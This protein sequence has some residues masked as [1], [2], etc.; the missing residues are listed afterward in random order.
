MTTFTSIKR[1]RRPHRGL[2]GF[3]LIE[4]MIVV[5]VIAILASVALPAYNDYIRRGQ[6]QEAFTNLSSFRIRLEQ[7]Y[8]DNKRYGDATTCAGAAATQLTATELHGEVKYF[9]YT[10]ASVA[11]GST[12]TITATGSAGQATGHIYTLNQDGNRATTRF[13][14][15]TSTAT[16]WL[17]SSATC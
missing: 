15:E 9:T 12:Y 5:A 7:F 10:C 4:L 17:S 11:D 3:T 1:H 14:G 8:Q 16:C 6:I 13:K 2:R